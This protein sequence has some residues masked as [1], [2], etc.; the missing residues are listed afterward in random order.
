SGH[1]DL[2]DLLRRGTGR[3]P[4]D[5]GLTDLSAEGGRITEVPMSARLAAIAVLILPMLAAAP[6]G[7]AGGP[8]PYAAQLGS[9]L[10]TPDGRT[11]YVAVPA[12]L[13]TVLEQIT[14]GTGEVR[15]ISQLP[16]GWGL[17]LTTNAAATSE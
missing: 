5:R 17:P 15:R 7:G 2:R 9:G 13:G 12:P 3:R 4:P 8:M 16:G 14:V 6:A 11:R 10:L 1:R